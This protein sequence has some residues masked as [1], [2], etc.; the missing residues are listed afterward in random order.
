LENRRN[1][2]H[3]QRDMTAAAANVEDPVSAFEPRVLKEPQG[4]PAHDV[5]EKVEP[6]LSILAAGDRV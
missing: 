4:C 3:I 6:P 1:N 2:R 5:G